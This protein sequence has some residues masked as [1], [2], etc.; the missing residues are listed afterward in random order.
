MGSGVADILIEKGGE[1]SERFGEDISLGRILDL[2]DFTGTPYEPYATKDA[3]EVFGDPDIRLIVMTIGGMGIAYEYSKRA[4]SSGRHVVTSNKEVVAEYGRE[5]TRM[6]YENG[7]RFLFEASS[8]GGIPVIRPLNIC[9]SANDIYEIQG[10]LNG[11]TNYILTKMKDDG[12]DFGEALAM[13][14]KKGYAEAD[15]TADV[16]GHDACRKIAILSSVAY[17]QF[18]DYKKLNCRGIRDVS[19]EDLALA[20]RAGYN[21]KLIGRSVCTKQGVSASVEPLLL[22]KDHMLAVVRSVFNAIMVKGTYTGDVMFYGKGAGK[23]P[24]ASAVMGDVI[25]ILSGADPGAMPGYCEKEAGII[26][27]PESMNR[28]YLRLKLPETGKKADGLLE[29]IKDIAGKDAFVIP[30]SEEAPETAGV[31]TELLSSKNIEV[32]LYELEDSLGVRCGNIIKTE[33]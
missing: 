32:K 26:N 29:R 6:A 17:G 8:G 10:I 31:I 27:D 4:L 30:P 15:P 21:I 3:E 20:D 18:V 2:R 5:L 11:T 24:T 1:L 22:K 25:E 33:N 12:L 7:V 13:A 19:Y 16:D 28:Y 9:L 23:L 14:Q